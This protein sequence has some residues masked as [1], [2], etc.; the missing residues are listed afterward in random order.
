MYRK[1]QGCCL[2][3][4]ERRTLVVDHCHEQGHVRGLLCQR[5]NII[6]GYVDSHPKLIRLAFIYAVKKRTA[7]QLKG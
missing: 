1:Q 4:K 5:C 7:D 6:V 3:C 2:I